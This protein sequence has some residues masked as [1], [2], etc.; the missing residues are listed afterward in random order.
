[1]NFTGKILRQSVQPHTCTCRNNKKDADA[2]F[3]D[4]ILH[5]SP[6]LE[7]MLESEQTTRTKA[8]WITLRHNLL[9]RVIIEPKIVERPSRACSVI[10]PELTWSQRRLYFA[11]QEQSSLILR[12]Y[13]D[14]SDLPRLEMIS[15]GQRY[16]PSI[17]HSGLVLTNNNLLSAWEYQ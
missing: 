1:M 8:K 15:V 16:Y 5:F 17:T 6:G 7:A 12:F 4:R 13:R 14:F 9:T 10:K 2:L 3:E 11:T